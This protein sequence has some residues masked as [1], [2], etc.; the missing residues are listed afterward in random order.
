MESKEYEFSDGQNVVIR[1]LAQKMQFVSYLLIAVGVLQILTILLG[2]VAGLIQGIIGI[3]IG[4]WTNKAA[5]AFKQIVQ[6][7]GNDISNL[8]SALRE[9]R[10][11]YT[12]QYW[13]WIVGLVFI[14]LGIALAI[15]GAIANS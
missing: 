7:R 14:A 1:E 11:L 5:G 8:M 2:N 3:S 9:L 6:T 15:L 10:K 13:L 4:I 12:L